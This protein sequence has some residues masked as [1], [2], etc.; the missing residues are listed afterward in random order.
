VSRDQ[1][2]GCAHAFG[3]KRV[4]R[5]LHILC[6]LAAT[7]FVLNFAWE[8]AQM[9]LYQWSAGLSFVD[10]LRVCLRASLGDVVLTLIAYGSVWTYR[11]SGTWLESAHYVDVAVFVAT[12]LVLTGCAEWLSVRVLGR[13]SYDARMPLIFGIGI[14]PLAQWVVVPPLALVLTRR[15]HNREGHRS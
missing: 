4:R 10:G 9:H 15:F 8:M 6:V 7:T 13:W 5:C 11:R 2:L 12:G 3:V 14:A 1:K